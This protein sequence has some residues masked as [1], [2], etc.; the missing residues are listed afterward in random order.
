MDFTF[1]RRVAMKWL[2]DPEVRQAIH[3]APISAIG[4]WSICSDMVRI[5][6][7]TLSSSRPWPLNEAVD[8]VHYDGATSLLLRHGEDMECFCAG[9]GEGA[10]LRDLHYTLV[11]CGT[12]H[13]TCLDAK[14]Q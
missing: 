3:A 4:Q 1:L 5:C 14:K 7:I 10:N 6:Y 9:D 11:Y 13:H 8:V 12:G 2:N